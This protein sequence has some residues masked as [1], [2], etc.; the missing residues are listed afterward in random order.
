M[1]AMSYVL[2]YGMNIAD[3]ELLIYQE[4]YHEKIPGDHTVRNE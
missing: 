1:V 4:S 3:E 2:I